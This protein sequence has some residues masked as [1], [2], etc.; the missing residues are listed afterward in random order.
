MRQPINAA[1][2]E[3]NALLQAAGL[4]GSGSAVELIGRTFTFTIGPPERREQVFLGSVLGLVYDT[5][6][7]ETLIITSIQ[8]GGREMKIR[9]VNGRFTLLSPQEASWNNVGGT[10]TIYP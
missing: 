2:A 7:Q 8:Y 3:L 1:M 9:F 6:E 4:I 10:L 5:H